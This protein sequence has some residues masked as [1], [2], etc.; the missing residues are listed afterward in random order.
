M[1]MS[2]IPDLLHHAGTGKGSIILECE[3]RLASLAARSFPGATVRPQILTSMNGIPTAD[4]GWLKAAGGANAVTLMGSLPRWLRGDIESFPAKHAF[5]APEPQERK[6]WRE[7]FAALGGGPIVGICWR[8]GKSGGHRSAQYAP[9]DGWGAFLRALPGAIVSCQYDASPEEIAALEEMSGRTI[10][11]P[12]FLDQKNELDRTAAM[13]SELDVLVS[14][15]T[16]VAWL[17]AGVGTP[18]LK[19]LYDTSWTAFGQNYEPLGP[20]C[21]CVMPKV[22]GDWPDVFAQTSSII[23]HA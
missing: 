5:L 11:V 10:F 21:R 1:F 3:P 6:N 12:P 4:Y 22:R 9:L 16:A 13:L 18:T 19:L 8:S 15:P 23:T 2:L 17:G 14:A 7:K 20:S